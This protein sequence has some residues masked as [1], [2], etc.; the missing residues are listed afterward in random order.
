VRAWWRELRAEL[1]YLIGVT[2]LSAR[3]VRLSPEQVQEKLA[4]LEARRLRG[5]GSRRS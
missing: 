2:W 1:A 5:A 4:V 3:M